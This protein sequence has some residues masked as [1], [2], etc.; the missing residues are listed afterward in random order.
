MK[1]LIVYV[2]GQNG[3]ADEAEHY[4]SLFPSYDVAGLDYKT[5]TPW[6]CGAEI[7]GCLKN[8][9]AQ[10]DRV[11]LIGNSIG[12]FFSMNADLDAYADEVFFISPVA[13]MER[14]ILKMMFYAGVS[15]AEL[16]E[17]KIIHT[18]FGEDLSWEY[19]SY[20]REHPI[21]LSIPVHV[22]YGL[23]DS[24][25]SLD[26]VEDFARKYHADLTVMENGEHWFHTEE[27][28][29]FLDKWIQSKLQQ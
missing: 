11:V 25:I 7:K 3:S 17:K 23:N 8:Y 18:S 26:M 29:S 19:L 5:S 28:M 14:L 27:Q 24:I 21:K 15:E 16:K 22:L 1:K 6:E 13:D 12:A 10:F 9:R 4:K 2:H 20:V